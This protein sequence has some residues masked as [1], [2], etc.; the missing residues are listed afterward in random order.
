MEKSG[1]QLRTA[2]VL[3]A[4][5]GTRMEELTADIPKPLLPVNNHLIIDVVLLKLAAQ[6]IKRV[7]INLHYLGD[8]VEKHVGN[9]ER[10][11]LKVFYSREEI[12]LD[13]GGGIANAESS[14]AGET[15]LA[16]NADVLSDISLSILFDF[17]N[18]E[19]A[20]ATMAVQP[21]KN[22]KDYSLV[23]YDEQNRLQGFLDKGQPI[24]KNYSSGIFTGFQ[25]LTPR[26][27]AYL[28]PVV[29]SVI[30]G[31]YNPA[32]HDGEKIS[33]F[34]FSGMWI[35]LGT[36][37]QYLAFKKDIKSKRVKLESFTK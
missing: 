1:N 33:V 25:I 36:K 24:P 26:A 20:I 37:A 17:H 21:S 22:N 28:K 30:D 9:G 6:G 18:N 35:D 12:L 13:T 11:G 2:M 4:G 10:Y 7:V 5:F 14:F 15:I 27:R 31:F 32:L 3:A 23:L 8:Q 16:A 29:Q 19:N 34:P